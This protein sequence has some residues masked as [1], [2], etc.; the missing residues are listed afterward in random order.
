[1]PRVDGRSF[2]ALRSVKITPNFLKHPD[3]SCLIE[4]GSTRVVCSAMVEENVPPFLKGKGRGWVT[5][6]YSMLPA[7]SGQRI[8]RERNKVGGRTHE[9]Q[10]L[11]GR[12]LRACVDLG[13]LGERSI[14]LD[15]DVLDADGG[16]RTA[17][18][19]G[20]Y[21]ALSLAFNKL[22]GKYPSFAK[23]IQCAVAAVSVGVV[24]GQPVLDLPYEEDKIADV[25][26]NIVKTSAN[27]YVEVQGTAEHEP[28]D[29][30]T[31]SSLLAVADK[32]IAQLFELQKRA[33]G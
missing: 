33:L 17:S 31:L 32:G 4:M 2:D 22:R 14:L 18:V 20:A 29:A 9:I 12:S 26:M 15:C 8:Q 19:T 21:V 23:A 11:I 28:F 24:N 13:A 7:S 5:A 6:E 30:A 27:M 1:M 16:T 3:G 25:D 10:R